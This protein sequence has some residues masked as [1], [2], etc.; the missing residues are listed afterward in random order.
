MPLKDPE[1]RKAYA[2]AYYQKNKE[3]ISFRKRNDL[4]YKAWDRERMRRIRETP[5]GLKSNRLNNWKSWGL[6]GDL[7]AIYEIYLKT[8]NCMKCSIQ[9]SD[10]NKKCMD[11]DHETG[12]YRAMLCNRCNCSNP[13]DKKI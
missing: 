11:H 4:E 3:T 8:T 2:K 13:L 5:E 6:V 7:E 10:G 9:F 12:E 1:A